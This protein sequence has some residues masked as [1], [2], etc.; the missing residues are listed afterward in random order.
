[1]Q[2]AVA[3]DVIL[4]VGLAFAPTDATVC[5]VP[6]TATASRSRYKPRTCAG[7]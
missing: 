3:R 5:P 1:M 7:V 2:G 6:S 4:E